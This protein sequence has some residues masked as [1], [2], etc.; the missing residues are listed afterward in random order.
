[1]REGEEE[2]ALMAGGCLC[3]ICG[4]CG[5]CAALK[6]L[7]VQQQ[8]KKNKRQSQKVCNKI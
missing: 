2:R 1:M 8:I 4:S 5:L 3:G 7:I 6:N